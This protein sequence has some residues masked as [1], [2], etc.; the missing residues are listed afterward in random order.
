MKFNELVDIGLTKVQAEVYLALLRQ[1]E[2]SGG[3]LAKKL[4]VDRSFVYAVLN[5]L[6]EKGLVSYVKKDNKR[7]FKASNPENL[8]K[9]IDEKKDKILNI[10]EKLQEIKKQ[11]NE[12]TSVNIYE[13][14]AGLKVYIRD[15]LES[16]N[17]YTFGGGGTLQVLDTLKYDV[18]HYAKEISKKKIKGKLITSKENKHQLKKIYGSTVQIKVVEDLPRCPVGITIFKN[19]T[20]F[21]SEEDN[22][23]VVVIE[24]KNITETLKAYFENTWKQAKK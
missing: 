9:D 3:M 16:T 11:A 18:P 7:L 5:S 24:N 2:Q 10:V 21:Y 22:N 4:S 19:K 17:F 13:G 6:I 8:L 14:K 12:E 1:P 15:I 23:V 20:A